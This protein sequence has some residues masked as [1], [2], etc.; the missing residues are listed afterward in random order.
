M[1][2]ACNH[3]EKYTDLRLNRLI[4]KTSRVLFINYGG[5]QQTTEENQ[6]CWIK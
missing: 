6:Q 5:C 2:L 3:K 4:V 1:L